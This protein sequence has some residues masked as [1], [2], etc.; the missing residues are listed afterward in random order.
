MKLMDTAAGLA[1]LRDAAAEALSLMNRTQTPVL[2]KFGLRTAIADFIDQVEDRPGAPEITYRCE[3]Q[4]N[5][6][7]PVLEKAIFRVAQEAITNACIHSQSETVHVAL[8]REDDQLILDVRDNGVGFDPSVV[9]KGRF[10]LDGIR[11]RT[12]LLG[13][14][15]CID[16]Q[17]GRGTRIRATFPLIDPQTTASG[18]LKT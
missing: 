4:F 12:R 5:R 17:P 7:E 14:Q 6:L 1:A 10:G 13:K 11:E 2:A 16:S 15:L 8:L 9:A 3:A 18:G